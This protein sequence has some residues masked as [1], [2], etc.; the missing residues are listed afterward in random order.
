LIFDQMKVLNAFVHIS[1][2][3]SM[4]VAALNESNQLHSVRGRKTSQRKLT[5]GNVVYEHVVEEPEANRSGKGMNDDMYYPDDDTYPGK[6]SSKGS[7]G[8]KGTKGGSKGGGGKSKGGYDCDWYKVVLHALQKPSQANFPPGDDINEL[9]HSF[10]YNSPLYENEALTIPVGGVDNPS[11]F[12]SGSCVRFQA[13]SPVAGT[14]N[15]V[16]G[17]GGCDWTYAI[18]LGEHDGTIEVSG[19]LFDSVQSTMSVVG[20]TGVFIGA[21]GQVEY[22][23]TYAPDA[24]TDVFTEATFYNMTAIVYIKVCDPYFHYPYYE[25]YEK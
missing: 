8:G 21:E 6:G 24:G 19:E 15:T 18:A 22:I 9:G 25:Y 16:A 11:A 3:T 14:E 20:G 7:K 2:V 1:L 12:V 5:K 10:I 13:S 4:L 23:P 17:A